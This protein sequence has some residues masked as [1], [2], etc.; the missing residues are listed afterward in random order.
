MLIDEA[1]KPEFNGWTNLDDDEI[2]SLVPER[3]N[4]LD[5]AN[6]SRGA[7]AWA[8]KYMGSKAFKCCSKV[9]SKVKG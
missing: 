8:A 7:C 6:A 9:G 2:I 4:S 1:N 5:A 3:I